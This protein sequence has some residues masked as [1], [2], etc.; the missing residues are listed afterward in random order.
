MMLDELGSIPA[1]I[2][3]YEKKRAAQLAEMADLMNSYLKHWHAKDGA[4]RRQIPMTLY[5]N[6]CNKPR[7]DKFS[8]TSVRRRW[9]MDK[10]IAPCRCQRQKRIKEALDELLHPIWKVVS[11]S[12]KNTQ[13]NEIRCINGHVRKVSL[14]QVRADAKKCSTGMLYCKR[15]EN[16]A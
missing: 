10:P 16:A 1:I 8:V 4:P 2:Q 5:C 6:Y 9:L 11:T 15:C 3:K 7:R 12:T 13:P 14:N